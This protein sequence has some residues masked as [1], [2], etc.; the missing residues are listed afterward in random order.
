MTIRFEK[1]Q[2]YSTRSVGDY[3]CVFS[4]TVA[5]RTPKKLKTEC[6]K[7]LHIGERDGVEFVKP[8]GNY[9]MAPIIRARVIE[10]AQEEIA[11]APELLPLP[12]A[13]NVY[14]MSA[15]RQ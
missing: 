10:P 14:D 6:G 5:S 9:S 15:Y 11:P 4:I 8:M 1:H 13:S 3:D 12:V 2:T 7:C